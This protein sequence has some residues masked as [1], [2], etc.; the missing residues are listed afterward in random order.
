MNIGI[1]SQARMTSTRLP[2]KILKQAAG[3][4]LLDHHVDRL[5]W[6]GY[7]V[8]IATTTNQQDDVIQIFC[9]ER[10]LRFFRGSEDNVLSRYHGLANQEN[11]DVIVRVTSDCPLIDG[12]IIRQGVERFIDFG[13]KSHD[14]LTNC[15][16]RT[17][18]RG[19]DFEIFHRQALEEMSQK[20]Q[21]E[22]EKEHVTPYIWKSHPDQFHIH[23]FT[24][25]EDASRYR[26][27]VDEK[28]DFKL[29]EIL[30]NDFKA[31][32]LSS[33]EIIEILKKNPEV[34]QINAHVE[35][36]KV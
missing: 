34:S 21:L 26:V 12:K 7:P 6:S 36:K 35:Q 33:D 5:K 3:K 22:Y 23:H 4:S 17:F 9:Q 24:R 27:T 18:P 29:I 31:H 2:G 20:A 19:F 28:D 13:A 16:K 30:I 32:L 1:V 8:F 11:L 14:Y 15:Q 10:S 25:S